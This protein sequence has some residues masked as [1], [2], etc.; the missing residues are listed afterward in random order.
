[1]I[2]ETPVRPDGF[3][4]VAT[5]QT[6]GAL[7]V[8]V[9]DRPRDRFAHD[10]DELET[11]AIEMQWDNGSKKSKEALSEEEAL[12]KYLNRGKIK[13][14]GRWI[15]EEVH[16]VLKK[17]QDI[18]EKRYRFLQQKKKQDERR[19]QQEIQTRLKEEA[20][21]K[22]TTNISA[23]KSRLSTFEAFQDKY[24][25]EKASRVIVD[26]QL[27]GIKKKEEPSSHGLKKISTFGSSKTK[28]YAVSSD[29]ESS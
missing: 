11:R 29:S 13:Y 21:E 4:D 20:S 25:Q 19:R 12:E 22:K 23:P 7:M 5:Q 16:E 6:G 24:K 17:E 1:M 3:I 15:S 18:K 10:V 28:A 2:D 14:Q 8:V 26:N 9:A 27:P